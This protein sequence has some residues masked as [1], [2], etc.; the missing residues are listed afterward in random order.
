VRT[1]LTS[2]IIILE[3]TR[4]HTI[5]V[6]LMISNLIAFFI[7]YR[8]Q[9]QPIYEGLARQDGIHLPTVESRPERS[10]MRVATAMRRHPQTL[11]PPMRI[12]DALAATSDSLLDAWPVIDDQGLCAM[13]E[14]VQLEAAVMAGQ[15]DQPLA[16][17]LGGGP[18]LHRA[19]S[20]ALP[21]LHPDH[22][23]TL[24]LERMGAMRSN[25]LPVVSRANVRH[26][27]GV[28]TL[29]DVL[30]AYGVAPARR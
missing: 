18:S 29:Q 1:P 3:L 17:L 28:I 8:L 27:L 24:A 19:E 6:P 4:D 23:L 22:S 2:V 5:I 7:S 30:D 12:H 11:P 25:V 13:V 16:S 20:A 14:R 26:L 9:P 15:G 21:H 10:R